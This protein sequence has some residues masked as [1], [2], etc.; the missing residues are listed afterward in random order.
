MTERE[1]QGP[2]WCTCR[3]APGKAIGEQC[4]AGCRDRRLGVGLP[5]QSCCR[6]CPDRTSRKSL[7]L[8]GLVR[9][10]TVPQ[11]RRSD[12][13]LLCLAQD[14]DAFSPTPRCC[15]TWTKCLSSGVRPDPN[16]RARRATAFRHLG[17][18]T[19]YS[20][21]SSRERVLT[22]GQDSWLMPPHESNK[23]NIGAKCHEK[24][25][26]ARFNLGRRSVHASKNPK[27]LGQSIAP[28]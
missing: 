25:F 2:G 18:R 21:G 10:R 4:L 16:L 11:E 24:C 6:S 12:P 17:R 22:E 8:S 27:L 23:I 13:S 26:S 9:S 15:R 19:R 1:G 7:R 5:R 14:R 20:L 3:R 28:S